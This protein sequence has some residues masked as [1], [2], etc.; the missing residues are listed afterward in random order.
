VRVSVESLRNPHEFYDV[1]SALSA[2]VLGYERLLLSDASSHFRLSQSGGLTGGEQQRAEMLVFSSVKRLRHT[3]GVDPESGYP[4]SG[5]SLV[6]RDLTIRSQGYTGA[7][8]W[9]AVTHLQ[10]PS[11]GVVWPGI[12]GRGEGFSRLLATWPKPPECGV[13]TGISRG[14][15][16]CVSGQLKAQQH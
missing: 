8:V 6:S 16:C 11:D 7:H 3:T 5:Y 12:E 9:I 10:N 14:S 15:G 13:R 2:F 1:E 4:T